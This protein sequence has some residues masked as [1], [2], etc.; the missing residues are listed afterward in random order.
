VEILSLRLIVF[1]FVFVFV[2]EWGPLAV[3]TIVPLCLR[4]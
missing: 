2:F 4:I 1:V 3:A